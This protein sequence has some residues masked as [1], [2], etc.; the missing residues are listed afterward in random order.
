LNPCITSNTCLPNTTNSKKRQGV[1]IGSRN[2]GGQSKVKG[3]FLFKGVIRFHN[4]RAE[5]GEN[6]GVVSKKTKRTR[7]NGKRGGVKCE[8]VPEGESL[9]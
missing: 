5:R 8:Q 3:G 9:T 1:Q 7:K 2:D 6:L 4:R